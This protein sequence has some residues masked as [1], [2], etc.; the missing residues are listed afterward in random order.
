[1]TTLTPVLPDQDVHSDTALIPP[2]K[3]ILLDDPV[4]TMEFVVD[5]LIRFFQKD[6]PTAAE[7]MWEIHTTG[8]SH[9]AT[10]PLEQAEMKQA[11]VHQAAATAGF[12]FRCVVEPA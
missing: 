12:P 4:T 5:V 2:Y 3:V 11:Q 8:A 7:L 1:M 6:G 9:V 10:L